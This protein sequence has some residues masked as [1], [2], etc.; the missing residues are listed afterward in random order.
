MKA[1]FL[2]FLAGFSASAA[3]ILQPQ[4]IGTGNAYYGTLGQSFTAEDSRVT[5]GVSL[6]GWDSRATGPTVFTYSLFQGVGTAG[7][8]LL[9]QNLTLQADVGFNGFVDADFSSVLLSVGQVYSI[10]LSASTDDYG[11]NYNQWAYD[12][13]GIPIPGRVDYPGGEMLSSGVPDPYEDLTFRVTPIPE[14]AALGLLGLGGAWLMFRK[15][16]RRGFDLKRHGGRHFNRGRQ[17][18]G[19][20]GDQE[21]RA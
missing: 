12:P 2:W 16:A 5:I 17:S 1:L 9:Q 11:I 7:P 20:V 6:V 21:G 14:P 4:I 18:H 10:V 8:M 13:S 15:R 3:Q 19:E